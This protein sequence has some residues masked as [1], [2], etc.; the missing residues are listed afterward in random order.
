MVAA[1]WIAGNW[2][3]LFAVVLSFGFIVFIHE[4]GHFLGARRV[5][6]TVSEFV[7]GFGPRL[8]SKKKD[9]TEYSLRL[10]AFGGF[11]KLEGEDTDEAD[12]DD[13]GNIQ[14]KTVLQ[15]IL[16]VACGPL[17]NYLM[18]LV[19]FWF[20]GFIYGVG[21]FYPRPCIGKVFDGYP[22]QAAGLRPGDLIIAIDGMPIKT[23]EEMVGTIHRKPNQII[24]VVVRRGGVEFTKKIKTV[25]KVDRGQKIGIIGFESDMTALDIT[26]HREGVGTVLWD[27]VKKVAIYTAAPVIALKLILQ[28]KMEPKMLKEGSAGPIGI[29][30]MIFEMHRKGLGSL[31]FFGAVINVCIGWINL[32]PFP[33]LDGARILFLGISGILRKPFDQRK[34]GLIHQV[35]FMI[36]IVVVLIFTYQDILRLIQGKAIFR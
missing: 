16:V 26:F 15:R 7:L 2:P 28:K 14:N 4:L 18:A 25:E 22:A 1:N 31:L 35:G 34:E 30:Q 8:L 10:F 3:G 23:Q 24:T 32:V 12:P 9:K 21:D 5:G 36:L 19:L 11:V 27:G 13:P 17:M 33:P 20:V 6:V 29:A